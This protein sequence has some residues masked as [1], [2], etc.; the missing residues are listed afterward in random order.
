MEAGYLIENLIN[1]DA[2]DESTPTRQNAIDLGTCALNMLSLVSRPFGTRMSGTGAEGLLDL[3]FCRSL[4]GRQR[5]RSD[6]VRV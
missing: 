4:G 2:D 3:S 6:R 1:E 5:C